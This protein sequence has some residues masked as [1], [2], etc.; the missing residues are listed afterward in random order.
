MGAERLF[1]RRGRVRFFGGAGAAVRAAGAES[2]CPGGEPQGGGRC[3]TARLFGRGAADRRACG[4]EKRALPGRRYEIK[5]V[6][7]V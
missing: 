7:A 4:R 1:G 6:V 2:G 3:G 5:S